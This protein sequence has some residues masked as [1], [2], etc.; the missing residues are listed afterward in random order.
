[1]RALAREDT[2]MKLRRVVPIA[3]ILSLLSATIPAQ[4]ARAVSTASEIQMGQE[5]D[6][7]VTSQYGVVKD[8]LLTEWVTDVTNK[9]WDQVARTD[10][11]YNIKIL[12]VSDVNAFST[13]GGYVYVDSGTLD[14]VQSDDELAAVLGHETGH[15]ERRHAITGQ[16]KAQILDLLF[17]IASIF[18]PLV[19]RFG[20]LAEAGLLAKSSRIQELQADQYGLLLMSRAGYDPDA[21]VSMM[22]HLGAADADHDSI[23]DKYLADHP[24]SA[25]RVSHLMGYP[26]LDPK[27]RTSD[28]ILVQALHD[29]NTARYNIAVM[30]FQQVLKMDPDNATALLHLGQSQIAIGLPNKGAQTLAEAAAKGSPETRVVAEA[31]IKNLR[32]DQTHFSLLRPNLAPLREQLSGAAEREGEADTAIALRRDP[33][34]DQLKAVSTRVQNISYEIPDMSYLQIRPGSRSEAMIKNLNAMAR[35]IDIAYGKAQQVCDGIG[36]LEKNKESGLVKENAD[37]LADLQAPLKLDQVPPE[38]LA[39]L[40]SY[41]TMLDDMQRSDGDMIRALDVSRSSLALLDVGLGDLDDLVR[42]LGIA[43][44]HLDY[45]GDVNVAD[46]NDLIPLMAKANDSL[47]RAA[48]ASSQGWQLYNLARARQLQSRITMLGVGFPEDRYATL[49]YALTERVK[50]SGIDYDA[51]IHEN[52]TP[53]EV[54]S[55]AIVAADTD[56]TPQAVIDEAKAGNRPIVD[57]ANTREMSAFALEVFLGLVY[58]DYTDDPDKEAHPLGTGSTSST[59]TPPD[60]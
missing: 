28:Q 15:I 11:P 45:N 25:D 10:V 54:V 42:H 22:N 32:E 1:M 50:N 47:N 17:G 23:V 33:A 40:P 19:Y 53:G 48:V 5:E 56:T 35:A 20:Q 12:D 29:Q 36:S 27:T 21:M 60:L 18:S 3:L 55:A 9:L 13:L 7:Q 31:T 8:P 30:K 39:I 2:R 51:M 38:S 43:M 58:L 44:S 34:K 37:I 16:A 14:F 24:P 4:P 26:E 49:Q 6:K 57:V 46:Y 41:P 59:V 52:L